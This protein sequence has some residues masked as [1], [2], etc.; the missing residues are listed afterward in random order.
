MKHS[1]EPDSPSHWLGAMVEE[2]F[3]FI[4]LCGFMAAITVWAL[5]F[6]GKV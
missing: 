6:V 2:L 4:V 3:S 1:L 5:V